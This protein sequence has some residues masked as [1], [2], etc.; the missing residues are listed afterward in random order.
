MNS[1]NHSDWTCGK[2]TAIN[3]SL[4]SV[5]WNCGAHYTVSSKSTSLDPSQNKKLEEIKNMPVVTVAVLPG[6]ARYRL[7]DMVSFQSTLG[8]GLFSEFGSTFSN[9]FGTESR[10]INSKVAGSLEKCKEVMRQLSY[11]MGGNAV[12]GVDFDLSTNTKDATT[13]AA[14]GTAVFVENIDEIFQ[15][16]GL[17]IEKS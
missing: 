6:N 14:Q 10:M 15:K 17:P 9:I 7:I 4:K 8:T 12:I 16:P 11:E 3:E 5:C 13:I 1:K 2:C